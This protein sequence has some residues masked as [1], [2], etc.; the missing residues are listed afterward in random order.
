MF[1][2]A[3][4][5]SLT[6][7]LLL[8]DYALASTS[9][10]DPY[11]AVPTVVV[12]IM[13]L[14]LWAQ[15]EKELKSQREAY[16]K[17]QEETI[18][19]KA[20]LDRLF[21]TSPDGLVMLDKNGII[22]DVNP[23]F[24]RIFLYRKDE[25]VGLCLDDLIM[26]KDRAHLGREIN[27]KVMDRE[28]VAIEANRL[29]GDGQNV[30]VCIFGCSV[31]VDGETVGL[32]GL[33]RD[34]TEQRK[35]EEKVHW[36]AFRDELTGLPNRVSFVQEGRSRVRK[37]NP[38]AIA[39]IDLKRFKNVNDTIGFMAGDRLLS[40]VAKRLKKAFSEDDQVARLGG[41]EFGILADMSGFAPRTCPE[42][43]KTVLEALKEPFDTEDS[44]RI[45]LSGAVGLA[46]YP[47]H[48]WEWEELMGCADI[49]VN[50][51]KVKGL[52][53]VCFDDRMGH[54]F[55][56]RISLE[57]RMAES[58]PL[59]RG[60]FLVYQPK[61]DMA[62]GAVV[63]LEALCRWDD[64]GLFI[65]PDQFIPV[66]EDTGMISELGKWVLFEACR[67]GREW[68]KKGCAVP[69]SVNVSARQLLKDQIES[70]LSE[71]LEASAF[72]SDLLELEITE[73]ALIQDAKQ[74]ETVLR[75][76]KSLGVS[77][78]IDDFGT[79]YSSLGYLARFDVDALK[80]DK[81]FMPENGEGNGEVNQAIVKSI[82]A[83]AQVR[84][85]EVVAEGVET[86][87]QRKILLE[88]GCSIGQGYL[89]GR[90]ASPEVTERL[91]TAGS[92]ELACP[93]VCPAL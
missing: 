63:G 27:R 41:D 60:F 24:E 16:I 13:L 51:A 50:E 57:R 56:R 2:V 66:A 58:I 71:I 86:D 7:C 40:S 64:M 36:L 55:H 87:S 9:S 74:S 21:Q 33:Y 30:R 15:R 90:P 35:V 79:G 68:I 52:D 83:L 25:I 82:L 53:V 70:Y 34:V 22:M 18:R 45:S 31:V 23:A 28:Q 38:F 73:T 89:F 88:L 1:L 39:H 81:V 3:T 19:Q 75:N 76:L 85:L 10:S 6:L 91:L 69:M 12:A 42:I 62:T 14:S 47:D 37:G 17:V 20:C 29:R 59:S 11:W 46:L 5:V 80:I 44:G 65:P 32:Y 43:G 77:L 8:P 72:P 84:G 49:A 26:G 92:V 48:G 93:C 78:S 67:Q 54:D 61:V 4:I